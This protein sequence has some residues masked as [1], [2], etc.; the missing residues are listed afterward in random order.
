MSQTSTT[1][2]RR[3]RTSSSQ[4]TS[5]VKE[6][7]VKGTIIKVPR[8]WTSIRS[9]PSKASGKA[10]EKERTK[11]QDHGKERQEITKESQRVSS[12]SQE[13][14]KV[15]VRRRVSGLSG[16]RM[17]Q[18]PKVS[19]INSSTKAKAKVSGNNRLKAK[20]VKESQSTQL[21]GF[22]ARRVTSALNAGG[23]A[24]SIN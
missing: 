5:L 1:S 23:T 14:A 20:V 10:K 9:T 18:R 13:R 2:R 11:D 8:R 4:P 22:A 19:T 16:A 24:Q 12:S 17:A 7:A 21:A 3:S 15:K 6:A